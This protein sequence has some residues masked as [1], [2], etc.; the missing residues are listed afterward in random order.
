MVGGPPAQ[1]NLQSEWT[2]DDM[3]DSLDNDFP[4]DAS[5]DKL[6][7]GGPNGFFMLWGLAGGLREYVVGLWPLHTCLFTILGHMCH[8]C[9]SDSSYL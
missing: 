8:T 6:M 9:T 7:K 2:V 4:P 5:W 1:S 3:V